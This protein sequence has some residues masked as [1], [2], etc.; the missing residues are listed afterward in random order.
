LAETDP[1]GLN[2]GDIY[3]SSVQKP[4]DRQILA[5]GRMVHLGR[6]SY[7]FEAEPN[8]ILYRTNQNG[9]TSYQVYNGKGLPKKR[10][11]L[12]GD[13]HFEKSLGAD[14]PAPHVQTYVTRYSDGAEHVNEGPV[15]RATA[16]EVPSQAFQDVVAQP[17]D[18]PAVAFR[19]SMCD[20]DSTL[21]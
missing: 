15:R 6:K 9:M 12:Q 10:V 3:S 8:E 19:Q 2:P 14:V 13:P 11:D 16:A 20:D 1:L 5:R 18:S 7:P 17:Y 4:I 21:C